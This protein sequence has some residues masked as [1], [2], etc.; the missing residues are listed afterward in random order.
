MLNKELLKKIS[1]MDLRD[2][3]E[4]FYVL[5]EKVYQY[6]QDNNGLVP[7]EIFE[8]C[9]GIGGMTV[10]VQI[11]NEVVGLLGEHV[12]YALRKREVNEIGEAWAGLYHSTCTV[13]NMIDTPETM[14]DR[15]IKQTYGISRP[16]ESLEFLGVTIHDEPERK[17]ACLTVVHLRKITHKDTES[18]IGEWQVFSDNQIIN[19]DKRIID[20]NW[21]LLEWAMDQ[22]RP[23][24]ADVRKGWNRNSK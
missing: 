23:Q 14:L 21:Y 1:G 22:K 11:I 9:L 24:F 20:H 17:S 3:A 10:S 16:S 4:I 13:G 12:G 18:F 8:A 15:N 5:A 7:S 2:M 6:R 19:H